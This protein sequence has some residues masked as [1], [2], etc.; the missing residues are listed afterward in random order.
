MMPRG[1]AEWCAC[2][3]GVLLVACILSRFVYPL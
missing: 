2:L 3:A 1:R